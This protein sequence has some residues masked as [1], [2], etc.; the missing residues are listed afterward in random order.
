MTST[1]RPLSAVTH[2]ALRVLLEALGPVETSAFLR[3]SGAGTGDYTQERASLFAGETVE[4]LAAEARRLR[5]LRDSDS[6]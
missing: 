6:D 2:D 3:Q 1:I 5:A 4:S